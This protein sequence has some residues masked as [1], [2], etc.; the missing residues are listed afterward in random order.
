MNHRRRTRVRLASFQ[1]EPLE[2]RQ[3][4]AA[5]VLV[6]SSAEI[7]AA[8]TLSLSNAA[9][10]HPATLPA[11]PRAESTAIVSVVR[12]SNPFYGYSSVLST[13]HRAFGYDFAP[14]GRQVGATVNIDAFEIP[15]G[16]ILEMQVLTGLT[17]WNG[18]GVPSFAPVRGTQEVNLNVFGQNLRV[19]ARTDQSTNP[20][21]GFIRQTLAIGVSDTRPLSRQMF[22]TIGSGGTQDNFSRPGGTPGIYAFSALWT[23]RNASGVRDSVPVTFVFRLGNVPEAAL[24]AAVRAFEAPASRPAAIVAVATQYVSPDGPGQ[25]FIRVNVQYSDPVS[26]TGRTPQLPILFDGVQRMADLERDTPRTNVTSLSFVYTPTRQ[27]KSASFIRLGDS[28]RLPAGGNLVT[29]GGKTAILSLPTTTAT[30]LPPAPPVTTPSPVVTV[31]A[32]IVRNTTFRQGTT[33]IIKGEVHVA[34]GVTLTIEDGVTVLITNGRTTGRLLDTSALIFDSGS[35]LKAKTVY[36]QAADRLGRATTLADNG[37]V[38]FLGTYRNASKDGVSVDTSKSVGK[39]N[40]TADSIVMSYLGRVDPRGG[41]G[42][43]NMFDDIDGI[44]ILGMGQTEW[45][46]KA[47]QSDFSGDDGFDVTNSSI[48]MVSLIVSYPTEDGLNASSSIVNFGNTGRLSIVMSQS[49]A[50]DRELFD[51]EVDDG[52]SRVSISR[53]AYVDL[54]GFW[55]SPY[56]E[57]N[58]NSVDMPKPPRRGSESRWYEFSGTLKRGPAIVYSINAD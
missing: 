13:D 32:D 54:H 15:A 28:I 48:S 45:N 18:R 49:P 2:S 47:V 58:L 9:V 17:Y 8:Q 41:D 31:S 7:A 26:V 10:I 24:D 19:G 29:Q 52:Q 56:D 43:D 5:S 20:R 3:L 50:P 6:A 16:S 57:V 27:D 25:P 22:V 36:F 46:V 39:S 1:A 11:A 42:N 34:A 37:G 23:V 53:G 51:F 38:F 55:G 33:Y 30:P 40:F 35:K 4:L 21:G 12:D 44:S 14:I